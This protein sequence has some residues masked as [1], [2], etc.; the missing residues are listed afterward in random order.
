ME[1][2]PEA[3]R[4]WFLLDGKPA[5][6]AVRKIEDT[7]DAYL[8]Y[9]WVWIDGKIAFASRFSITSQALLPFQHGLNEALL[10]PERVVREDGW[11]LIPLAIRKNI[12]VMK[13]HKHDWEIFDGDKEKTPDDVKKVL[14]I[15]SASPLES[16]VADASGQDE[17]IDQL[18]GAFQTLDFDN[19]SNTYFGTYLSTNL[20]PAEINLGLLHLNKRAVVRFNRTEPLENTVIKLNVLELDRMIRERPNQKL[21]NENQMRR[22]TLK[23]EKLLDRLR[24]LLADIAKYDSH[25]LIWGKDGVVREY[26]TIENEITSLIQFATKLEKHEFT[27]LG[28]RTLQELID[29][30]DHILAVFGDIARDEGGNGDVSITGRKRQVVSFLN[31][32]NNFDTSFSRAYSQIIDPYKIVKIRKS[33]PKGRSIRV[34][35][36]GMKFHTMFDVFTLGKRLGEGGSGWVF[37]AKDN[38]SHSYALKC[39]KPT[40]VS[41]DR[42]KRFKNEIH[43]CYVANHPNIVKVIDSGHQMIDKVKCPFYVMKRYPGTLR[44]M[45]ESGS[46]R[47]HELDYF[48]QI[49]SAIEF[50]HKKDIWHRDLK[51]EN[52]LWDSDEKIIVISDFGI[53][54][55]D[56]VNRATSVKT[57][58]GS[59]LANAKY[60][61]PEQLEAKSEVDHRADIYALGLILNELYTNE[62][63]TGSNIKTIGECKAELEYLDKVVDQMRS[64]SPEKRYPNIE[65]IRVDLRSGAI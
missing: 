34:P 54:H 14:Q 42:L 48:L 5:A 21:M 39:L 51:P 61:A 62:V 26:A 50:A 49:L 23:R 25:L 65:A 2:P 38:E 64:Q 37:E 46:Q 30:A 35:K 45:L 40:Q 58:K 36:K 13:S 59:R 11:S 32:K 4:N 63:P 22:E 56:R 12:S 47:D 9:Y 10:P 16:T 1:L 44:T 18:L 17:I 41:T 19:R 60:R 31:S 55:F 28:T 33:A 53:A 8:F 7:G 52:I 43:F 24:L 27:P 29:V 15:S 57:K 3:E 6:I 20:T